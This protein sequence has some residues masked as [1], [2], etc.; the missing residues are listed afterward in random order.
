MVTDSAITCNPI[1]SAAECVSAAQQLGFN[2]TTAD[3]SQNVTDDNSYKDPP[4][5][6]IEGNVLKY[7]SDESQ[8][9]TCGVGVGRFKDYCLCHN[10]PSEQCCLP[11]SS[12]GFGYKDLFHSRL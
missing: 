9:A 10:K 7:N 3:I 12:V 11:D 4:Y 8:N 1:T 5:C 6:Y 2:D